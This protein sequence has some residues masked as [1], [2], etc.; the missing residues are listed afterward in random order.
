MLAGAEQLQRQTLFTWNNVHWW[1][2]HNKSMFICKW[3]RHVDF[4]E[5]KMSVCYWLII[6]SGSSSKRSRGL[7]E[8][9]ELQQHFAGNFGGKKLFFVPSG[10][11]H[12][13][14]THSEGRSFNSAEP[15]RRTRDNRTEE[16][17]DSSLISSVGHSSPVWDCQSFIC[18]ASDRCPPS[19][20]LMLVR[21]TNV[22]ELC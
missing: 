4:Q 16:L 7:C 11:S 20:T 13:R 9:N 19:V 8:E 17:H 2:I 15:F 6:E 14:N 12:D 1:I 21:F 10:R 18:A 3:V 22:K 5:G